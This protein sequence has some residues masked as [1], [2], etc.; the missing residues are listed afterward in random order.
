M[1]FLRG[2]IPIP[3]WLVYGTVIYFILR[4]AVLLVEIL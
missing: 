1:D 3:R 2:E 4:L